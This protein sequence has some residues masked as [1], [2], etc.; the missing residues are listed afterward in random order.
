MAMIS[1]MEKKI[2]QKLQGVCV[3]ACGEESYIESLR[4]ASLISCNLIRRKPGNEPCGYLEEE[5]SRQRQKLV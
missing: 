1:S 4:K 2:K 5:H 3:F